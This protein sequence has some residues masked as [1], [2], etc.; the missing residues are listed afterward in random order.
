MEVS[1]VVFPTKA[2]EKLNTNGIVE[3]LDRSK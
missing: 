2:L 1:Q 3:G